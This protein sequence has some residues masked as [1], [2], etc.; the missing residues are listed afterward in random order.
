MDKPEYSIQGPQAGSSLMTR[1]RAAEPKRPGKGTIKKNP[2]SPHPQVL[3]HVKWNSYFMARQ[4]KC[5]PSNSAP[6]EFLGS[7]VVRTPCFHCRTHRFNLWL[8]NQGPTSQV[9]WQ[10]KKQQKNLCTL[11]IGIRHQPDT[12]PAPTLPPTPTNYQQYLL[13]HKE[14][15]SPSVNNSLEITFFLDLVRGHM[16]HHEDAWIWIKVNHQKNIIWCTA[17]CLQKLMC[18]DFQ[19]VQQFL[20]LSEILFSTCNAQIWLK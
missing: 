5:K 10:K 20:E 15:H 14:Q 13:S 18:L 3:G 19:L 12:P 17:L 9:A 11:C 8:G 16:T 2:E 7:P 6:G 4:E 1:Q